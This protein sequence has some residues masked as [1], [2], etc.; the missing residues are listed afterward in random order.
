ML[1]MKNSYRITEDLIRW[2]APH[3]MEGTVLKSKTSMNEKVLGETQTLRAGHSN[4]T[5]PKI[6]AP[7]QT[8]FPVAQECQN[9][10]SW[11]W[12]LPAPTDPVW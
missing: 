8:P 2:K 4:N 1:N 6:F 9:L 10:I 11:R 3:K 12:S 7:P 5:E